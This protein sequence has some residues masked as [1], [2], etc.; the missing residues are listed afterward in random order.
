EVA[1]Q[2]RDPPEL[3]SPL[4]EAV[5]MTGARRFLRPLRRSLVVGR[6]DLRERG[7]RRDVL[8]DGETQGG[9]PPAALLPLVPLDPVAKTGV[10]RVL[11]DPPQEGLVVDLP[12]ERVA[13]LQGPRHRMPERLR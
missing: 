6:L 7:E 13:E 12:G 4:G 5:V 1:A 11:S 2:R 3:E 8:R 10:T 9:R